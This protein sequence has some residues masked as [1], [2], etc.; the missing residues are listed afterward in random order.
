MSTPTLAAISRKNSSTLLLSR[1]AVASADGLA[2]GVDALVGAVEVVPRQGVLEDE[3]VERD[4]RRHELAHGGV[5]VGEPQVARVHA[6]R[7]DGHV[8]L[9]DELLVA[10]ERLHGRP[11]AG[12]VAVEREDDLAVEGVVVE[13]DAAQ[14]AGV[15]LAEGRAAGGDRGR[16]RRPGGRP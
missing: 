12:L 14:H 16:A 8:R 11:L 1:M 5:A 15:V 6:P 3:P 9:R 4:A 7:L 2:H 10:G 13:Q